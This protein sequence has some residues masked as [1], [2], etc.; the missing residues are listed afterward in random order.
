MKRIVVLV[1][2]GDLPKVQEGVVLT[3]R[4]QIVR[5]ESEVLGLNV[6]GVAWFDN[7]ADQ[8]VLNA[9]ERRVRARLPL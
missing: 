2:D 3:V 8:E 6:V 9:I 5:T 1:H 4:P 7:D